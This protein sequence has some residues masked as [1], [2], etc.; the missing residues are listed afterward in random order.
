MRDCRGRGYLPPPS[1]PLPN[2]CGNWTCPTFMDSVFV[3]GDL[4][5][6]GCGAEVAE[7]G[8]DPLP[9]VPAFDVLKDRRGGLLAPAEWA[10]STLGLQRGVE[11]LHDGVVVAVADPV[12]ADPSPEGSQAGLVGVAGVLAPVVGGVQQGMGPLV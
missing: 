11:A 4:L 10:G 3:Q 2:A 8:V 9:V 1:P 12:H 6:K 5:L 7:A